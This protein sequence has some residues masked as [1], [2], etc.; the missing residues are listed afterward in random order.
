MRAGAADA[1]VARAGA[2]ALRDIAVSEA[3]K[4]AC[5][6]ARA[7]AAVVAALTTHAGS[8]DVCLQASWALLS[9]AGSDPAHRAAVVAADAVAPL[10]AALARHPSVREKAHAALEKLGYTDA[11]VKKCARLQNVSR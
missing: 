1:S 4:A 7:P 9:I 10:A 11:G 6:V 3:G 5:V 2:E 8:S